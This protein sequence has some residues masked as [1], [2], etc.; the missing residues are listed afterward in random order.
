[1]APG[2]GCSRRTRTLAPL[3]RLETS[4]SPLT[5]ATS[6]SSISFVIGATQLPPGSLRMASRTGSVMSKPTENSNPLLTMALTKSWLAPA[7][8]DR[9]RT[10][11]P[12]SARGVQQV[13]PWVGVA[14]GWD[15]S[16][17]RGETAYR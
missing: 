10:S 7:E 8:S 15:R 6:A 2:C 5:S 1:M 3:G 9:T 13:P 12:R 14:V 11:K 17:E 16:V 4:R